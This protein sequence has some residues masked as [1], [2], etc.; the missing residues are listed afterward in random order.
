MGQSGEG[1]YSAL[2]GPTIYQDPTAGPIHDGLVLIREG[3]I[4]E[5]GP[6]AR[7]NIPP[8]AQTLDCSGLTLV[9]AYWNSHV[10]FFER[11][12]ANAAEIPAAEL[13]RQLQDFLTRY[14]FTSAFDLSSCWENTRRLRER[15]ESGEVS[16]PRIRSTGEGI[17]PH[18][19]TPP[20]IVGAM[21]GLMKQS[22]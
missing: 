11:K 10:H 2:L 7:I 22:N 1:G 9:A 17:L 12:W 5:V 20:D 18:G 6:R 14:G 3:K 19:A 21:M 8:G 13:S 15:I 4:Q 16:G